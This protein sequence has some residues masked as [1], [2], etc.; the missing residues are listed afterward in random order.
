MTAFDEPLLH[1]LNACTP[2]VVLSLCY[3]CKIIGSVVAWVLVKMIGHCTLKPSI[4]ES[5]CDKLMNRHTFHLFSVPHADVFITSFVG[6]LFKHLAVM[7]SVCIFPADIVVNGAHTSKIADL[8]LSFMPWCW[9]PFLALFA[10]THIST[11]APFQIV[12]SIVV[13]ISVYMP[14]VCESFRVL[15]ESISDKPMHMVLVIRHVG[16]DEPYLCI[17][18]FVC[19]RC[20]YPAF[21]SVVGIVLSDD[22]PIQR[23]N[24]AI[25]GHLIDALVAFNRFPNLHAVRC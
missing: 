3:P 19:F 14:D 16:N 9:S 11:L 21:K 25:R 22:V 18:S 24:T 1:S 20:Q 2:V 23:A 6:V 10:L 17:V 7:E 15:Y 13:N 5:M 8:I 4:Y 12:G